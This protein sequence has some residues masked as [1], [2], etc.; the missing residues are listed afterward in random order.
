MEEQRGKEWS[1]WSG[2]IRFTP[3]RILKPESE[4]EIAAVVRGAREQGRTVRVAGAGHSSTELVKTEDTLISLDQF[5][6]VERPDAERNEAW[7]LAGMK[8]KEAGMDLY[9]YGLGMHNTGDVDVQML[10]GAI[11][12]GTHGTGRQLQNLSSMLIGARM[13][14]GTGE[15]VEVHQEDD[16]DLLRA[17]RVSLGTFGIF[18][19]MRLKLEPAFH[20]HRR[21]WC[22]PLDH[23]LER[24]EELSSGNRNV[25]FY[26]YP[27]NDLTKIRVMNEPGHKMPE[28]KGKL[29]L[30]EEGPAHEVLPRERNIKFDEIEF[31]LPA[32]RALDCF[33][34]CRERIRKH[35]RKEV[36]W[37][38]LIR[39]VAQDDAM[40]SA[41]NGRP[42][43]TLSF[44]HNAGLPYTDYFGAM[45]PILQEYGGRPHWGK[46][47]TLKAGDIRD[48]YPEWERWHA[49]RRRFDP[50]GVF[51]TPYLRELLADQF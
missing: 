11:G 38:M 6:G 26:W 2:S 35:W 27:R 25:D 9:R 4:E 20:L 5:K 24:F 40:L 21:E 17:L 42:T 22:V 29:E 47:H 30:D 33:L 16:P 41:A 43:I 15:I 14:T 46:K 37:R 10:A 51:M 19:K 50:D 18:T 13:I 44:H 28:V 8:V 49:Y 3:S 48:H 39:T 45:Q 31:H 1:N 36:A 12:T 23:T 7:V 32:D 34:E